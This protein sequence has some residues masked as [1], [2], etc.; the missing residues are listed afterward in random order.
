MFF[1]LVLLFTDPQGG[2]HVGAGV[3]DSAKECEV[4]KAAEI[5]ALTNA[6]VTEVGGSCVAVEVGK[7]S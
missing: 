1:A 3:F 2:H 4:A 5:K 6:G 7:V